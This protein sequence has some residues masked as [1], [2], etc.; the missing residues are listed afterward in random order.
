MKA[1]A[2]LNPYLW[3]L[4]L[5]SIVLGCVM[6]ML[7]SSTVDNLKPQFGVIVV[8]LGNGRPLYFK[9][10]AR[11]LSYDVLALS[12]DSDPCRSADPARDYIFT[13]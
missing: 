13:V 10:E 3:R 11:G 12:M 9:R 2:Q 8:S 4:L 1:R 7:S 5:L 6:T